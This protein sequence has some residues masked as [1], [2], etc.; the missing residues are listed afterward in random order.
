MFT[1]EIEDKINIK[2]SKDKGSMQEYP[3]IKDQYK[4]LLR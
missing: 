2:K 1:I 3:N 4:K